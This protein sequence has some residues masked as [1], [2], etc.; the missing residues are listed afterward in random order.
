MLPGGQELRTFIEVDPQ[1]AI[2]VARGQLLAGVMAVFDEALATIRSG[3][4]S[5]TLVRPKRPMRICRVVRG[6]GVSVCWYLASSP[7]SPESRR[8][9]NPG[10]FIDPS[11]P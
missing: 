6:D 11:Q 5:L 3:W 8:R 9:D 7:H 10:L 4:A 2:P 1:R